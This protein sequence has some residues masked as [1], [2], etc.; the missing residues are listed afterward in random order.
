MKPHKFYLLFFIFFIFF[1]GLYVYAVYIPTSV[2]SMT[3]SAESM[4][5]NLLIQKDNVLLLY[6]TDQTEK[7]GINPLPF[8]NLDEYI[9][10]LEIQRKNGTVCPILYLQQESNTQG[11]DVYRIRPSPTNVNGGLPSVPNLTA[12]D[13]RTTNP[14]T[15]TATSTTISSIPHTTISSSPIME[16]TNGEQ[17]ISYVDADRLN[18]PYNSDNYPG[19]DPT[20]LYVG[21]VT[22]IDVVHQSTSATPVSDNPMDAN[23]GGVLYTQSAVDSGKYVDN[24][25]TVPHYFQPKTSYIPGIYD[26]VGPVNY[27]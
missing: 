14:F 20:G 15:K 6:N 2:E 9:N 24:N 5:P 27:F 16:N 23:W 4:C 17:Q 7:D 26:Q 12:I 21:K 18:P 3:P 13:E 11:Q 19:F 1:L 10:Y 22:P 8:F 25:I